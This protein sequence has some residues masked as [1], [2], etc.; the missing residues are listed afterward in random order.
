MDVNLPIASCNPKTLGR[1]QEGRCWG[2]EG[3]RVSSKMELRVDFLVNFGITT[4]CPFKIEKNAITS[5]DDVVLMRLRTLSGGV[6]GSGA[7]SV[8]EKKNMMTF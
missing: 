3:G 2:G 1:E 4:D 6:G 8:L 7:G 5:L